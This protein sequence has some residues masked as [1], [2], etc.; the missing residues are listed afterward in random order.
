MWCHLS[1]RAFG[2]CQIIPGPV[3]VG[4]G[5]VVARWDHPAQLLPDDRLYLNWCQHH[6]RSVDSDSAIP[7]YLKANKKEF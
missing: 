5:D 6:D 1:D 4:R 7:T 3:A 2:A